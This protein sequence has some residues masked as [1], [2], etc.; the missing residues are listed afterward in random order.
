MSAF[1]LSIWMFEQTHS[2]IAMSGMRVSFVLPDH[3]QMQ[4]VAENA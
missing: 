3:D 2:A 4:R 1:A